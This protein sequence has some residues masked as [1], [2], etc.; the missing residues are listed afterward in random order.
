MGGAVDS[1]S[2]AVGGPLQRV[3]SAESPLFI[4]RWRHREPRTQNYK[5]SLT[6]VCQIICRFSVELLIKSVAKREAKE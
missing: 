6:N 1:Q 5:L 4:L 2:V 3:A